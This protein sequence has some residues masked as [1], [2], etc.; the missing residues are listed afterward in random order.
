MF[1]LLLNWLGVNHLLPVAPTY[2]LFYTR[3]LFDLPARFMAWQ[4]G[5]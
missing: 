4:F 2:F 3:S 1:L 5:L